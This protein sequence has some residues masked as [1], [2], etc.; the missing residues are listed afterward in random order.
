MTHD[1]DAVYEH[2]VLRPIGPLSLANGMRVH[3]RIEEKLPVGE[4]EA[5]SDEQP[6]TTLLE[7]LKNVVGVVNDL[8]AGLENRDLAARQRQAA[9]EL[10]DELANIPDLSPDDGLSS[11]DHDRILYVGPQ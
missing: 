11:A 6:A 4:V 10:D 1:V 9:R 3:L 5:A 7:R 2:G 8:P